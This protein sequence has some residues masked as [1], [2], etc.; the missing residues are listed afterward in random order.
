MVPIREGEDDL[1]IVETLMGVFRV[2]DYQWPAEAIWVLPSNMGMVPIST[3]L[4]DLILPT[5]ISIR[6]FTLQGL[7]TDHKIIFDAL[8]RAN[9]TLRDPGGPIHIARP[10]LEKPVEMQARVLVSQSVVHVDHEP[11]AFVDFNYR[12]RPTPVDPNYLPAETPVRVRGRPCYVEV[13]SHCCRENCAGEQH[14]RK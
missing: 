7:Y 6:D 8:P 9:G 4:V 3:R 2:V 14:Q 1:R 10:V 5:P 11:V 12:Y 13:V